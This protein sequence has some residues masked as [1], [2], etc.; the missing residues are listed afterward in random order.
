MI[1]PF[2]QGRKLQTVIPNCQRHSSPYLP[3]D[4]NHAP[5]ALHN[6]IIDGLWFDCRPDCLHHLVL[7]GCIPGRSISFQTSKQG[8]ASALKFFPN[9]V[10][11]PDKHARIPIM[12][13]ALNK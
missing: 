4:Y 5:G 2:H 11:P 7:L 3:P 1:L 13:T 12:V 8:R 6:T 10:N 9:A